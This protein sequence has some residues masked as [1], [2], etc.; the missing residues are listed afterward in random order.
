[1][2]RVP[3]MGERDTNLLSRYR[4]MEIMTETTATRDIIP[5]GR[6]E[7]ILY[8]LMDAVKRTCL[9]QGSLP[10]AMVEDRTEGKGK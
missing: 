2:S 3:V 9:T 1:M 5:Y 6:P 10:L 7:E 4:G 8:S